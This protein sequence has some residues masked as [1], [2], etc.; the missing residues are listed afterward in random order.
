MLGLNSLANSLF[1][2]TAVGVAFLVIMCVVTAI[3]IEVSARLQ[4]FL[5]GFEYLM[6]V[7]FSVVA[8]V[9]VYTV[10]PAPG[11]MHPA[12]SLVRAQHEPRGACRRRAAGPVHLLGLGHGGVG[13]RGDA[14]QVDTPGIAAMLSTLALVFIYVLATTAAQAFHGPALPE[15][16]RQPTC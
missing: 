10:Q 4:W 13:Q 1:W 7:I 16:Q 8:L 5:L 11:S 14:E 12:A 3:G 15:Q 6:L 9:K 2:V